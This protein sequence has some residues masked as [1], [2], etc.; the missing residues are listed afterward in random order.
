MDEAVGH[1]EQGL[2]GDPLN[3]QACFSLAASY[4]GAG[5]LE[6][7]QREAYKVLEF[8]GNHPGVC[9]VLALT[10]VRQQRWSDA[11]KAAERAS[12]MT[13][14]IIGFIAGL[15]KR[16]GEAD[17]SEALLQRLMPH[18]AYGNLL[19]F[20]I[21]HWLSGEINQAVNWVRKAIEQRHPALPVM[22]S[23]MFRTT[24]QWPELARLMN[25]PEEAR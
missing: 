4:L 10:Y 5:R 1:I 21:Y 13:P 18:E 20:C 7:A 19:G 11:L 25:L 24:P 8:G 23:I 17:R 9:I 3:L 12:P 2:K 22:V 6:D 15:L 16:M 14:Q